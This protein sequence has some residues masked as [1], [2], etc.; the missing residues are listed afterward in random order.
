MIHFNVLHDPFVRLHRLMLIGTM[1]LLFN[2]GCF[3]APKTVPYILEVHRFA[4]Q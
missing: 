1:L 2:R 3:E 4:V